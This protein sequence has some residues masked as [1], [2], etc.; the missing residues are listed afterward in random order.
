MRFGSPEYFWLLFVILVLIGFFIWVWQ[1]KQ[2]ALRRFAELDL[3]KKLTPTVSLT[4]QVWKWALFLLGFLFLIFAL[5]RPLWGVKMEMGERKGVDII[6]ALDVSK[7]MLARDITPNRLDRAKHEIGKFIDLLKG[8]RVGII[9]F[10]GES[11]V[12]CP[13]T[14]DY[15]AAHMFLD[16]ISTDWIQIQGTALADAIRQGTK[17]FRSQLK[18]HKVLVILSDGEDHQ[19]DTEKAARDAAKEGVVIYTIGVGSESGVPIPLT[20]GTNNVVYKKDKEG[21]LVM[22]RLNPVHLEKAALETKGKYFHGGTNLDLSVIYQEIAKMEKKEFGP[23]NLANYMERY[24]LPLFIALMLFVLEFLL[25]ERLRRK[26]E[27]KGR[28]EE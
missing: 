16:V 19:G 7:S 13:L 23:G 18:K 14:L 27:W 15:G 17:A 2:S 24:Q 22:T 8:D 26:H 6:F 5:V 4:L 20:K 3:I 11:Y 25:P 21:N 12:Q 1:L 10:A 28:I 9:V